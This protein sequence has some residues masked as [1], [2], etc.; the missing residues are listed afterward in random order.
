MTNKERYRIAMH[1]TEDDVDL[2]F[3]E[4]TT[5]DIVQQL[6]TENIKYYS[7]R[8][9]AEAECKRLNKQINKKENQV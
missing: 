5:K 7:N 1:T 6:M 4:D 3:I 2:Y 9:R 8:R